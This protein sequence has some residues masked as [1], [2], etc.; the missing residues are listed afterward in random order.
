MEEMRVAR[1]KNAEHLNASAKSKAKPSE[2]PNM[3]LKTKTTSNIAVSK[4]LQQIEFSLEQIELGGFKHHMLKE[5]FEQP[6][7][8]SMCMQ[9]RIDLQNRR[10]ILGGISANLRELM[11]TKKFIF[12]AC[13]TAFHAGL[14]GEFRDMTI[15]LPST[16]DEYRDSSIR[17][18]QRAV[19]SRKS[20][21]SSTNR[22][23]IGGG[24]DKSLTS[25]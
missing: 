8:L 16:L 11:R 1:A 17:A 6:Q 13:G 21:S 24:S 14:V 12:T 23:L 2:A 15:N 25:E 22:R 7:S 9:G 3:R 5:I 10:I 19:V 18:I 4:D 20:T